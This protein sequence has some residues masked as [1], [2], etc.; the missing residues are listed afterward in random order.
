MTESNRHSASHAIES[1][2]TQVLRGLAGAVCG[3]LIC[4]IAGIGA[5]LMSPAL[6]SGQNAMAG[7]FI[8]QAIFAILLTTLIAG[9]IVGAISAVCSARIA[10]LIVMIVIVGFAFVMSTDPAVAMFIPCSIVGVLCALWI[11][12]RVRT[13][14][15][16]RP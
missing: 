6:P 7:V 3:A 8:A 13:Y 2:K 9:A 14:G 4:S 16:D 15:C 10:W 5:M 12:R 11:G 1:P